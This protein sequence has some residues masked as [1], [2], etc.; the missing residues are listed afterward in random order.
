MYEK[1]LSSFRVELSYVSWGK[2]INIF[3]NNLYEETEIAVRQ[4]NSAA[5]WLL[6][7]LKTTAKNNM[8]SRVLTCSQTVRV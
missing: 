2:S 5:D 4:F 7:R 6:A 3:L 8:C 1:K